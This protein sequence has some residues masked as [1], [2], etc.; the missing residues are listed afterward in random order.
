MSSLWVLGLQRPEVTTAV[1]QGGGL[2]APTIFKMSEGAKDTPTSLLSFPLE[3]SSSCLNTLLAI[4]LSSLLYKGF[5]ERAIEVALFL[6]LPAGC[7]LDSSTP[8]S[9]MHTTSPV[10]ASA[11]PIMS[12]PAISGVVSTLFGSPSVIA[13]SASAIASR[14][15]ECPLWVLVRNWSE[16]GCGC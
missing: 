2:S 5:V 8:K 14:S 4:D 9:S 6:L 15:N 3:G 12:L 7:G 13:S 1:G 11:F 10:Q 16:C